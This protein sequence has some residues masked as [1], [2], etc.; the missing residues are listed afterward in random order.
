MFE[1]ITQQEFKTPKEIMALRTQNQYYKF[2]IPKDDE[3][4][5]CLNTKPRENS[6]YKEAIDKIKELDLK[7]ECYKA[8]DFFKMPIIKFLN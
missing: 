4:Y 5:T 2:G 3:P 1:F 6:R 8:E 7:L